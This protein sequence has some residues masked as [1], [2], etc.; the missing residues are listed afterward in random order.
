MKRALIL[1]EGQ[2]EDAFVAKVLCPYLFSQVRLWL[3]PTILT[4]KRVAAQPAFKGG[5][6]SY[7]QLRKELLTLCG[8]TGAV[9]VTTLFDYYGFP[10]DAPGMAAASSSGSAQQKVAKLEAAFALDIARPRF[11]PFLALHELEAWL[12]CG[13]GEAPWAFPEGADLSALRAI[14]AKVASPEEI[15]DDY[16]TAPS[17][18]IAAACPGYQKAI[19]GAFALQALGIAAIREQCPHFDGWLRRLE[20]VA[21]A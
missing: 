5:V 6:G 2:T 12:F 18:R 1:V 3:E 13:L 19:D 14:R 21:R 10:R 11:L 8:D 15:N 9:A 17:R 7:K 16:A 20:R 4:T